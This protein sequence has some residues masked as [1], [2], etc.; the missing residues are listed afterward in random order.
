ML[1]S[2][3][4][5][6]HSFEETSTTECFGFR[7]VGDNLDKN[8]KPRDMRISHQTTSLHYFHAY[9]L[10]DRISFQHLDTIST[11]VVPEDL[12]FSVFLPSEED[13]IKLQSNLEILVT[14]M[15]IKHVPGLQHLSSRIHHHIEH[16]YSRNMALKSTVV[17]LCTLMSTIY[18]HAQQSKHTSEHMQNT[19]TYTHTHTHT[20]T[21]THIH[22]V[23]NFLW[24]HR[25]P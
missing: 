20:Y 24:F 21:H 10:Q 3:D 5:F 25:C 12:N 14:R 18:K 7:L 17:C 6:S 9:A 4:E 15:L 22:Y 1:S 19:H 23:H 2:S 13:N 16:Q 8:V 11:M